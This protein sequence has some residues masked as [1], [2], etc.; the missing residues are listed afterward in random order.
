MIPS[1]DYSY[2]GS[3][4]ILIREYGAEAPLVSIGNCSALTFSP[5]EEVKT[6]LDHTK[7]GG[8][9]RKEVR[10]LNGVDMSFT[11]H[12][13]SAANFAIGLRSTATA[14]AAGTA[15]DETAVAYKGG[16]T[17]LEKIAT[18]ITTVEPAGGGTAFTEGSDYELRDGMLFIPS[19]STITDPVAGADNV[20]VTY[21]Y[22][23]Q[24]KVEALISSSKEYELVFVGLNEAQSGARVRVHAYRVSAG[25]IQ[26]MSLLGDDFGAGQVSGALLPE[27]SITAQDESQYFTWENEA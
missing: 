11:F 14:I 21:T 3:G 27:D 19:T 1:T 22:V 25:V 4:S 24:G 12:D 5:Q 8:N 6:L 18:A 9:K 10:R 26:E 16:Y 7:P 23:A 13:F 15:T 17:K 2:L 20:Q